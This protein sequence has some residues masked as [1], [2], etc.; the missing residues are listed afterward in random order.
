MGLSSSITIL[1]L[2]TQHYGCDEYTLTFNTYEQIPSF[3]HR[4]NM[5]DINTTIR[6]EMVYNAFYAIYTENKE[7]MRII[8]DEPDKF[9]DRTTAY[10]LHVVRAFHEHNRTSLTILPHHMRAMENKEAHDHGTDDTQ[11]KHVLVRF[12]MLMPDLEYNMHA[13]LKVRH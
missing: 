11:G 10:T 7:M 1:G 2:R 5:N 12:Q 3:I 9:A 8:I 13:I 4:D 6:D